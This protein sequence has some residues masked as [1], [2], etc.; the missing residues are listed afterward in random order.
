[1]RFAA[2]A[3]VLAALVGG[4]VLAPEALASVRRVSFTATVPAGKYAS[5]TVRAA[6]ATRCTITVVYDTVTSHARGLVAKRGGTI[7]WRWRVGTATHPGRWPVTV[8]CGKSGKLRLL[9]H[10]TR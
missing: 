6:P 4:L 10:V 2:A 1:M 5:L 3:V 9:L 8:N 7:T